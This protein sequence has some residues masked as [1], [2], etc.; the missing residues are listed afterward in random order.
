MRRGQK[1]TDLE[2]RWPGCLRNK[3]AKLSLNN[4][5]LGFFVSWINDPDI[6]VETDLPQDVM[7]VEVDSTQMQM[8]LS[9]IVKGGE[10]RSR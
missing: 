6:G 8:D 3:V 10:E 7:N 4:G 1:V 9:A 2:K 5:Q